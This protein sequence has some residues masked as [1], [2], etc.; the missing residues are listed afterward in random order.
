MLPNLIVIVLCLFYI[1]QKKKKTKKNL[2]LGIKLFSFIRL[3]LRSNT[4]FKV[5]KN[6]V[7]W[8]KLTNFSISVVGNVQWW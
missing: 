2:E 4:L 7:K 3:C 6:T 1:K 5:I 8:Y